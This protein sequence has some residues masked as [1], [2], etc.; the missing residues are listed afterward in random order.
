MTLTYPKELVPANVDYVTF[1]PFQYRTNQDI[2]FSDVNGGNRGPASAAP[3]VAEPI[4]LFM[5]TSSPA[6]DNQNGWN[7]VSFAGPLGAL[8]RDLGVAAVGT[9]DSIGDGG[10]ISGFVDKVKGQL[11]SSMGTLGG[12]AK[13]F[14]IEVI[15]GISNNSPSNILAISR[16]K[17]YSPNVEMIYQGPQ[18]RGFAFNYI[19]VPKSEEESQ[20]VNKIILHFKKWSSPKPLNGLFEIP[21]VW[22]IDYMTGGVRNKNMNAFKR[23]VL[24][25]VSIQDNSQLEMHMSYAGGAPITTTMSLM[26]QEVDIITRDD[27]E[28]G[29]SNRGY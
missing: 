3:A 13:Q 7:S 23:S 5:P 21:P 22:Q 19:F 11:D 14:G 1:R 8:K 29:R 6:V 9:I 12:A 16:G 28:D 26:F 15:A 2:P 4:V 25:S 20:M 24:T 10:S 18:V 27:H 17:I